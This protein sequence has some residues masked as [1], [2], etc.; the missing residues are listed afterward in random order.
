MAQNN[1][2]V[3]IIGAGIAVSELTLSHDKTHVTDP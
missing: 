1:N 3:A 2:N